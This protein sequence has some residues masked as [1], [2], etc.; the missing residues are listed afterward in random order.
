[1]SRIPYLLHRVENRDIHKFTV[2]EN[3]TQVKSQLVSRRNNWT[4]RHVCSVQMLQNQNIITILGM[5]Y[6]FS[7]RISVHTISKLKK[8]DMKGRLSREMSYG[9]VSMRFLKSVFL[10]RRWYNI[11]FYLDRI[12]VI[13]WNDSNSIKISFLLVEVSNTI[14]RCTLEILKR[15][16]QNSKCRSRMEIVFSYKTATSDS[17]CTKVR[18]VNTR[19][20]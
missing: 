10:W 20:W 7:T 5:S 2:T 17:Q 9:G 3:W 16:L 14:S 6:N 8:N 13:Y 4:I 15:T 1:M 19:A 18:S 12:N 11:S